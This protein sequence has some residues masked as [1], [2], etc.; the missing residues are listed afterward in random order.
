M[1]SI[2][3]NKPEE[4]KVVEKELPGQPGRNEVLLKTKCLGI[5]GTDLHAYHG[6]QP[7]FTYPRILGH[8]IAAQVVSVGENVTHLKEG[9]L[10]T[11]IPY[12]NASID[13]AVKRGK[14]NCGTGLSY[15]GVHE[16]GA[17]QEYFIYDAVNVFQANALTLEQI[18]MIEPISIGS[19]AVERAEI[20][21]DDIVLIVGAGP[22]GITTLI[23]AQL[24]AARFIVLDVNQQRL[25]FVKQKY[26]GVDTLKADDHTVDNLK[27]LLNGDLPTIVM[28]ATGNRESML[29]CFDYVA[30]GGMIVYVGI[31]VGSIEFFDPLLH[32]KEITLKSSRNSLPVDYKKIIRLMESGIINI[33]GL[34]THRLQFNTLENSF[35]SLYNSEERVI[36]AV[37][38]F[39]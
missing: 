36:K 3:L 19:H 14:P 1:K 23:M 5:C 25:D 17:M 37:V 4:F 33:D 11:V 18:A 13:Q 2:L 32:A 20:K 24:K 31:F 38:E 15:F 6:V 28:D 27:K 21:P 39:N 9:D 29:K 26:A 30:A 8:E 22:I 16:D 7:F 35:T 34:V 12:R 10:C